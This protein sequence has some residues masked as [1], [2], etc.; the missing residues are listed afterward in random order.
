[1]DLNS[2]TDE[3]LNKINRGIRE[4]KSVL[5]KI[6]RF[7]ILFG[8]EFTLLYPLIFMFVTAFRDKV[9]LANPSVVWITRHYT[10]DNITSFLKTSNFGIVLGY[11]MEIS[12][13]SA[14]LQASICSFVGYGFARF[15]F[16]FRGAL[17][18]LLIFT[19]IV[20]PQ[21]YITQIYMMFRFF[22]V[23]IIWNICQAINPGAKSLN[24]I[25]TPFPYWLQSVFG[26]GLR[27][28]LFIFIFRQFFRGLPGEIED[29][30]RIDGCNSFVTYFK[31]MLPNA[32]SAVVT[33]FMFSLVWH[34]NDYFDQ[35]VMSMTRNTLATV[36]S[37]IHDMASKTLTSAD[38]N[39]QLLVQIRAQAGALV[40]IFPL[41]VLFG[42]GQ[43][44]FTE[45]IERTGIVG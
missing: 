39:N 19:I 1:M 18:G 22:K 9:D 33:V 4:T 2:L 44:F 8:I 43:R 28:G 45:S 36:L 12:V 21:T 24:L 13:V 31:I 7:I 10:L 25:D 37:Q 14:I 40:S 15:H 5:W 26:M 29:A 6:I 27:S 17:F 38:Q 41:L 42:I 16:K 35:S 30:A 11:T 32:I 20:P 34:W 23:P 3:K